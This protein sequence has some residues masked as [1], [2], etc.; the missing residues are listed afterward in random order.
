MH[1]RLL[2]WCSERGEG[3]LNDFRDAHDWLNDYTQAG[4][5][6]PIALYNHQILGHVEVDSAR[7]RW[8]ITPAVVTA[9]D[10]SGGNALLVGARPRWLLQRLL[11]LDSDPDERVQELALRVL[12]TEPMPQSGAPSAYFLTGPDDR[13]LQELCSALHIR[14]EYRVSQ[15]LRDT[16]PSLDSYLSVGRVAAAPPG[17]EARR[18]TLE[19]SVGWEEVDE[20]DHDGVYEY[21]GYGAARY[22]VVLSGER[23][24]VDKGIAIYADLRRLGIQAIRYDARSL[25]MHVPARMRLPLLAARCAVLRTGLLPTFSRE[26]DRRIPADFAPLNRYDNIPPTTYAAICASLGQSASEGMIR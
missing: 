24:R 13:L 7:Q 21:Q 19:P 25:E 1:D 14:F 10:D 5:D 2:D 16:L 23:H 11:T 20:D 3:S 4:S 15:R 18:F 17:V 26:P 22:D 8:A 12:L 9:L 6:W